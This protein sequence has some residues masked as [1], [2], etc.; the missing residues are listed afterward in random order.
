MNSPFYIVEYPRDSKFAEDAPLITGPTV[1]QYDD[2]LK[3][4]CPVCGRNV[5]GGLWLRP[6]HIVLTSRRIPDFLYT[7][8][9]EIPFLL[10]DHALKEF[11]NAGLNGILK[12]EP[13]E[14][15]RYLRKSKQEVPIP[16]YYHV[17]VARSRITIDQENSNICYHSHLEGVP[18]PICRP[19]PAVRM[20][21]QNLTYHM[22]QYEGYDIFQTY[23]QGD[24]L[25]VSQ[26]F[27]D[28]VQARKLTNFHCCPAHKWEYGVFPSK[29]D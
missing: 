2:S 7:Y 8:S 12:A 23:E 5:S 25:F 18:C 19:V 10:S 15:S 17:E 16:T 14:Y 3:K 24:T 13:I 26:R 21:V 29:S 11:Q 1:P 20:A 28:F 9:D 27:I 4:V 22:E 6:R